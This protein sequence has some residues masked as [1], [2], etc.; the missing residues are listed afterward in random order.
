MF[1]QI[2]VGGFGAMYT[3]REQSRKLQAIA[4]GIHLR[5]YLQRYLTRQSRSKQDGIRHISK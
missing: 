3:T 1:L 2:W 5:Q 4:V